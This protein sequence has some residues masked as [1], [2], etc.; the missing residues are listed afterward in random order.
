MFE[1][2]RNTLKLDDDKWNEYMGYFNRIE[3]PAKTILLNENDVSKEMFFI[4]KGSIRVWFNNGDK[5]ITF[6][7]FF[8]HEAVGSI[9]SFLKNR[10]SST[11]IETIE[12]SVLWSIHKNDF[13]RILAEIKEIPHLRD[14]FIDKIFNRTFDYMNYFL[15]M[16]K[17]TPKERY[18]NLLK[19]RP[20]IVKRVPQH[21]IASYLGVSTVHLSRIKAT[22]YKD[23]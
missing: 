21:Y 7:F 20:E 15:S 9:E 16:I 22:L 10:P 8:E 14:M 6:Q 11:N 19:E 2:F 17:N 12:P 5:D 3:V 23:K 18:L 1:Q 4:E 13:N